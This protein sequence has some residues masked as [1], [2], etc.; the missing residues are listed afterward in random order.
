MWNLL[1]KTLFSNDYQ[2]RI[3]KLLEYFSALHVPHRFVGP[4]NDAQ[5]EKKN[6]QLNHT[7]YDVTRDF[8]TIF[9]LSIFEV[10]LWN[11][12]IFAWTTFHRRMPLSWVFIFFCVILSLCVDSRQTVCARKFVKLEYF[13]FRRFLLQNEIGHQKCHRQC[14][15][16]AGSCSSLVLCSRP[17]PYAVDVYK[18]IHRATTTTARQRKMCRNINYVSGC[19]RRVVHSSSIHESVVSTPCI[20]S[21]RIMGEKNGRK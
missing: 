2:H 19:E 7:V 3:I 15:V 12:N 5:R 9:H 18:N 11:F 14:N 6:R 20:R 8:C 21:H 4:T 16:L 1:T 13:H 17:W 10:V